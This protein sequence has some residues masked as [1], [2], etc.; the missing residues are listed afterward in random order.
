MKTH[1]ESFRYQTQAGWLRE[2]EIK[3]DS[4]GGTVHL[5]SFSYRAGTEMREQGIYTLTF[6][7]TEMEGLVTAYLRMPHEYRPA[8][9]PPDEKAKRRA[10]ILTALM[11][12]KNYIDSDVSHELDRTDR[13]DPEV[14]FD[15]GKSLAKVETGLWAARVPEDAWPAPLD[16]PNDA[17]ETSVETRTTFHTWR[18]RIAGTR[19]GDVY[20]QD[21]YVYEVLGVELEEVRMRQLFG[22]RLECVLSPELEPQ[23]LFQK[24][25]EQ[26]ML[27]AKAGMVK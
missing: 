14:L 15:M 19:P 9:P 17:G 2:G 20:E 22:K 12:A 5:T 13:K 27:E 26:G 25:G 7:A 10:L 21:G 4:P 11:V 3:V 8:A 18:A 6:T 24:L 1:T 16:R 23:E